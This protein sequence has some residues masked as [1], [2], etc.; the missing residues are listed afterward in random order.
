MDT[1]ARE[2]LKSL[3]SLDQFIRS[4][5]E[6]IRQA[7]EDTILKVD[8]GVEVKSGEI[9]PHCKQRKFV[10]PS[11]YIDPDTGHYLTEPPV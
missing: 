6:A 1:A 10:W 11:V 8:R 3:Q 9:C 7:I 5:D 2:A 4:V